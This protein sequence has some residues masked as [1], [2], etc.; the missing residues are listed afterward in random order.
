[1]ILLRSGAPEAQLG[2]AVVFTWEGQNR[3]LRASRGK[4]K[5]R[6][7]PFFPSKV[8]RF[9]G[10]FH[11]LRS[12]C[13]FHFP[14]LVSKGICHWTYFHDFSSGLQQMAVSL[15]RTENELLN[16]SDSAQ[17]HFPPFCRQ[18]TPSPS[19][20]ATRAIHPVGHV[21]DFGNRL[22]DKVVMGMD[23]SYFA[24]TMPF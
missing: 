19:G 16:T 12:F 24:A 6:W 20:R 7:E 3:K 13:I 11:L 1:M 18:G 2:D 14:L 4:R 9:P 10:S 17:C 8:D 22:G 23:I 5:R 21:W 15:P